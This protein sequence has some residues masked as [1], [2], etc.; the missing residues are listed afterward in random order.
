MP[1]RT[2]PKSHRS[3]TGR[4]AS[5]KL[6]RAVEYESALERDLLTLLEFDDQV[7]R[8][9]EQPVTIA[10]VASDGS[11]HHYTPD[12]LI[13]YC[14]NL[15]RGE[16]K[17]FE[18][19]EVKY[20]HDL[21]A[22]WS[23]LKPK[24]KAGRAYARERG[25]RFVIM[26]EREIRTPFLQN[27]RFLLGYGCLNPDRADIALLMGALQ[28]CSTWQ[29]EQ[30]LEAVASDRWRRAELI[31]ALWHLVAAGAVEVDLSVPLTMHSVVRPRRAESGR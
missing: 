24:L 21:F 19:V 30:L 2:I 3:I 25:W 10:Y 12:V 14:G 27:V 6:G 23:V 20:R 8:Y 7:L 9:E 31:P 22:E 17:H 29:V 26:T 18:L 16:P 1:T 4:I 11:K 5:A 15:A 13:T 28:R